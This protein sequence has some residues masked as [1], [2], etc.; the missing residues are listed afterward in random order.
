MQ[1]T[2]GS[3]NVLAGGFDQGRDERLRRQLGMLAD[4]GADG[5]AF[6]ECV[7]W[8][9]NE[10]AYLR[11][12]E[13]VLGMRGFLARSNH[14]NDVALFIRESPLVKV[15]LPRHESR[16]PYWHAVACADVLIG[17]LRCR[18]LSAH[19]APSSPAHRLIE[20]EALALITGQGPVIAGGDWNALPVAD[21]DPD[22]TGV[23]PGKARRKLDRSAAAAI[24]ETGLRDVAACLGDLT[25]TVGHDDG[26][27]YRCDRIY[28]RLPPAA[29]L[30]Y[31][32]VPEDKPLSDHRPVVASFDLNA[33]KRNAT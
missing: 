1:F 32:V 33:I 10:F 11:L 15:G 18:L 2:F 19:L 5:W 22:T 14:G 27:Y 17:D 21:P 12:T 8:A 16:P 24:E 7:G 6:Q 20:A 26:L 23:S 3:Y 28:A 29:M 13:E 31:Q 4:V 25:P 30:R 9:G